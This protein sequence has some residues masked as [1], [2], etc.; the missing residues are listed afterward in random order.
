MLATLLTALLAFW[1]GW[2]LR[3]AY[4]R[5]KEARRTAARTQRFFK[6]LSYVLNDQP[7]KA[8]DLFVELV[9]VDPETV[10]THFA[11]GNLYRQR[12][13]TERAIRIHQNILARWQLLPAH[14]S[15]AQFELALDFLTAG[16]I[17]RA[18][19]LLLDLMSDTPYR[20]ASQ[21]ELLTL[22]QQTSEWDKAVA[23]ADA[24]CAEGAGD[25]GPVLA[26]FYCELAEQALAQQQYGLARQR[27]E[28]ALAQDT[29]CVRASLIVARAAVAQADDAAF[30][31]TL[32][33]V[34]K[35]DAALFVELL[36]L[37]AQW[38]TRHPERELVW[39]REAMQAGAGASVVLVVAERMRAEL[40]DRAAG[41]FLIEQLK[42]RPSIRELL[43]LV[44][45]HVLHAQGS[46]RDSLLLLQD[47]LQRLVQRLP[48]Y[49]CSHC[50]FQGPVLYWRCPGCK[51]WNSVRPV[52]GIEGQ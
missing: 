7:D 3:R 17:D 21:K 31:A 24:M 26:H 35:Q 40:G 27:L 15:H 10:D 13:E 32:A 38:G 42:Q 52:T 9:K 25:A 49:R 18:E 4:H 8:I 30:E 19:E 46:T 51:A 23:I 2:F 41:E 34:L 5:R 6:G 29:K 11:L 1:A 28:V 37:L 39:L 36:P 16:I 43:R 48:L 22:Y 50:G 20:R 12:G 45:L 47:V 33:L 14:R 44:E